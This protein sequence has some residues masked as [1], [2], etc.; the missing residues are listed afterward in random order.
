MPKLA[1][2]GHSPILLCLTLD[3]LGWDH[4]DDPKKVR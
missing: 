1:A 2:P 4:P 3:L